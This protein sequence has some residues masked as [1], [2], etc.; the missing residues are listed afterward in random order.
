MVVNSENNIDKLLN[1]FKELSRELYFYV[2]ADNS[3]C[4][5][6]YS[7][8]KSIKMGKDAF[9]IAKKFYFHQKVKLNFL[10]C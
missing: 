1:K 5:P 10:N 9:K 8:K 6:N 2:S 4:N 3:V 7:Y